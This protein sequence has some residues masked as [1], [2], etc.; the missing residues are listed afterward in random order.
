MTLAW[1]KAAAVRGM[2][3]TRE[4]YAAGW[5]DT[6]PI[7]RL[8][9]LQSPGDVKL[10]HVLHRALL[11]DCE[12][13]ALESVR[14]IMPAPPTIV[15]TPQQRGRVGSDEWHAR[16]FLG[17]TLQVRPYN[18]GKISTTPAERVDHRVTPAAFSEWL[19][20]NK[21]PPSEHIAAWFEA[22]GVR[23]LPVVAP[24][25]GWELRS[26]HGLLRF[27]ATPAG[28]LVR[29]A[30]LVRWLMQERELPCAAAVGL[31]CDAL[32]VHGADRW[33]YLLDEA[34]YAKQLPAGHSFAYSP[35]LSFWET[36]PPPSPD[37]AGIAGAIKHMRGY[38]AESATP[39]AGNVMG[40]HVLDPLAIRLDKAYELWG[41]GSPVDEAPAPADS[42][43]NGAE[44]MRL[45][46][47]PTILAQRGRNESHWSPEEDEALARYVEQYDAVAGRGGRT[48]AAN[49]LGV[50]PSRIT[51]RLKEREAR[52]QAARRGAALGTIELVKAGRR[53]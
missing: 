12:S 16:D 44:K 38:W 33:L 24:P 18:P 20:A 31:V 53:S 29:L 4:E 23:R 3:L 50:K 45:P 51:Q 21:E 52:H 41:Y 47:L 37:D 2:K 49:E 35:S 40:Q 27:D 34:G 48:A 13:R 11:T 19:A 28:L 5:P 15:R 43:S 1:T 26:P 22:R 9:I 39:G 14:T 6:F 17:G 46:E 10:Q 8:A 7:Y 32:A 25:A 30:D 42:G 36:A